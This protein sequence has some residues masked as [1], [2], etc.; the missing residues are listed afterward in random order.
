MAKRSYCIV[1]PPYTEKS[2]GAKALYMLGD[3]LRERGQ[4]VYTCLIDVARRLAN[5][6]DDIVVYPEIIEGNPLN[7]KHVVRWLLY[8][9]GAYRGN[10]RFPSTDSVWG[11][12]TRIANDYGISNV[13]FLPTIDETVFVPPPEGTVRKGSCFYAH[14]FRTFYGSTPGAIPGIEI[15]NPGQSRAEIIKLLQTSEVFYAYEDTALIL[16]A[17]LCGCPV[18]C[19]PSVNFRECCGLD[20]FNAGIAWGVR[21]LGR[22]LHTLPEARTRY[23]LLKDVFKAQVDKF[24]ESTQA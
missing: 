13:L 5:P 23:L 11:Y 21:E 15:T 18:V 17:V 9:A 22:A 19:V 10:K 6:E 24:I 14:K 4:V 8:Y 1:A 7:A 12:T 16:E 20:D 3:A 2:A